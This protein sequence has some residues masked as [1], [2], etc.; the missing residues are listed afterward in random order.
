MTPFIWALF[1]LF[2]L[3][4]TA[5]PHPPAKCDSPLPSFLFARMVEKAYT[6][7]REGPREYSRKPTRMLAKT[8]ANVRESLRE[9]MPKPVRK[10]ANGVGMGLIHR[11]PDCFLLSGNSR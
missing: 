11:L 6:N 7:A 5:L 9:L 3:V 10:A 2:V 4:R 1:F 8:L